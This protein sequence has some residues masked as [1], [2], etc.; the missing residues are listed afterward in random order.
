MTADAKPAPTPDARAPNPRSRRVHFWFWGTALVAG[1]ADL[2]TKH[3]AFRHL[4]SGEAEPIVIVE[5]FIRFIH[6]ENRGGVFGLWQGSGAWL[7]F[8][9]VASVAVIYFAH[10][11]DARAVVLQLALGLVLGG[12]LGNLYDRVT[13]GFVRDFIDVTYWQG[14]HWPA[15]N[16]A[17]SGICV[18]AAYLAIHAFFFAPK[19]EKKTEKAQSSAMDDATPSG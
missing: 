15:F 2:A 5:G 14:K 18:G 4:P 6:A 7:V 16:V 3:I 9:I 8:G 10:R 19:D 12:A 11:R 17:D 1:V 13:F